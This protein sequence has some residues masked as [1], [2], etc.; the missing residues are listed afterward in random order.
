MM[1]DVR[2]VSIVLVVGV[3]APVT[4]ARDGLQT[5]FG[6]LEAIKDNSGVAQCVTSPPPKKTVTAGSMIDCM[7]ACLDYGCSCAYGANYHSDNG[8]CQL[9]SEPPDS[10]QQVPNCAYYQVFT[11]A[12]CSGVDSGHQKTE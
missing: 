2:V 12:N 5:C 10:F 1:T 11:S 7:K 4:T 9:H 8:T 3:L 6:E